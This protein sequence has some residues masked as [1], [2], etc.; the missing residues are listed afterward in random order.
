MSSIVHWKFHLCPSLWGSWF[1]IFT[2]Q[3]HC[4]SWALCRWGEGCLVAGY[5][6]L[7]RTVDVIDSLCC[8]RGSCCWDHCHTVDTCRI[9]TLLLLCLCFMLSYICL[10]SVCVAFLVCALYAVLHRRGLC[11]SVP[12]SWMNEWLL[13]GCL[14]TGVRLLLTELYPRFLTMSSLFL[15]SCLAI[16]LPVSLIFPVCRLKAVV[17]MTPFFHWFALTLHVGCQHILTRVDV[18]KDQIYCMLVF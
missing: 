1:N 18:K 2:R 3:Q 4:L 6:F 15:S 10:I 14:R 16:S 13:D 8:Q 11:G 9:W 5:L 12:I 7:S 17:L